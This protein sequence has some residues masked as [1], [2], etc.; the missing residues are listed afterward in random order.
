[1]QISLDL[2]TATDSQ[3]RSAAC[4][5]AEEITNRLSLRYDMDS[6]LWVKLEAAAAAESLTNRIRGSHDAGRV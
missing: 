6:D 4:A 2:D 3:L 5:I 1:M